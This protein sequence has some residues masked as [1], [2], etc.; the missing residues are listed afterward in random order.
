MLT[1]KDLE[2]FQAQHPEYQMEL[3][4]GEIIVKSLSGYEAAEVATR[5]G[6]KLFD[7]VDDRRLGRITGS[8]AGFILPNSDVRA[9]DVSF[10]RAERLR[11][12]VRSFAEIVPDLIVEVKSPSDTAAKLRAKIEQFLAVGTQVGILLNPDDRTVE[13]YRSGQSAIVLRD[14]DVLTIPDL[15]PGWE[16]QVTD[17]W[18]PQFD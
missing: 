11:R 7:W 2:Q 3:V 13:I 18:S 9:P 16:V 4:S 15:F 1:V 10:V 12:S 17:L 6:S 14:G 5:M 8:S